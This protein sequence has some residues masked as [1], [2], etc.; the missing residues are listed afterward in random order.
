MAVMAAQV[1]W[2]TSLLPVDCSRFSC[3]PRLSL[4]LSPSPALPLS[5]Q[6]C[7]WRKADTWYSEDSSFCLRDLI[8]GSA[9]TAEE[10]GREGGGG[11]AGREG[12]KERWR[13]RLFMCNDTITK[14][15]CKTQSANCAF[16][17]DFQSWISVRQRDMEKEKR[18]KES[19]WCDRQGRWF[20]VC[21]CLQR[22][23]N[24][25]SVRSYVCVCVRARTQIHVFW[26]CFVFI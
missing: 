2:H 15:A 20:C 25:I 22:G 10:R 3:H 9:P 16:E 7:S 18:E 1:R 19:G 12:R 4:S 26:N 8:S 14:P 11:V 5:C 21:L 17:G 13:Q 6:C 23:L 24:C